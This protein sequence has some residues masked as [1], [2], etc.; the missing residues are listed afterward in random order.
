M[1]GFNVLLFCRL[2][3]VII[4]FLVSVDFMVNI[5]VVLIEG[6]FNSICLIL[7]DEMFLLWWWIVFF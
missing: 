6:W 1:S 2:M 5:V 3:I 7:Y 4:L